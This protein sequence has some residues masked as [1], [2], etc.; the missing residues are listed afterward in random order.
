MA[1]QFDSYIALEEAWATLYHVLPQAIKWVYLRVTG[2]ITAHDLSGGATLYVHTMAAQINETALPVLLAHGDH[3]HPLTM[4]HLAQA[5]SDRP[6][7]SIYIP[8]SEPTIG[9][10]AMTRAIDKVSDFV[11]GRQIFGI[12]HSKGGTYLAYQKYVSC[13]ERLA[14]VMG[15][16]SRYRVDRSCKPEIRDFVSSL[17][18]S[19]PD[20]R[21]DIIQM[22]PVRDWCMSRDSLA[23]GNT[24]DVHGSHLSAL[25]DGQ[26]LYEAMRVGVVA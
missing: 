25:F 16:G 20:N 18:S 1:V 8:D 7:Y 3:S 6:V 11:G 26:V 12:G 19:I 10:G 2:Q 9:M 14:K 13:D 15:I 5:L 4:L 17:E 21:Q 23:R 24:F 22:F